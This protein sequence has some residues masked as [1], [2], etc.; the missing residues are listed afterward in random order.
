MSVL[1][2]FS[3][4][5]GMSQGIM[6]A[7]SHDLRFQVVAANDN[8]EAVMSTYTHNH[9][10]VEFT[11]GS[12]TN[13]DVKKKIISS[14]RRTTG[15][16]TV[17]LMVGGP[18]CKGFSLENK[19]TRSMDNPMNHLVMHYLEMVKR[20]KP[21]AFVMENVPGILA[22]NKGKIIA[23]LM[24][25]LRGLGYH[26]TTAWLLNAADFGV[27]QMRRRAFMVGSRSKMPIKKTRT[28]TR[29]H[30]ITF[31]IRNTHRCPK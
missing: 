29:R 22:M 26:N 19:M 2:L 28:Y 4:P 30:S 8:N 6:N 18:P 13:E 3:G 16:S 7:R 31:T 21:T 9:P 15:R 17:D 10:D 1:D 11:L 27:P 5:G 24:E 14:I 25:S 23:F 12:I 20:T